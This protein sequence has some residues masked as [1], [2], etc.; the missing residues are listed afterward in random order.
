M[1]TPKVSGAGFHFGKRCLPKVSLADQKNGRRGGLISGAQT[2]FVA[3]GA[4]AQRMGQVGEGLRLKRGLSSAPQW[5]GQ[6][7]LSPTG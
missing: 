5:K 2:P 4:T 3:A 1:V 7:K 6:S